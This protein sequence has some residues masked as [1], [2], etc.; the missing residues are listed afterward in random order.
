MNLP[1]FFGLDIGNHSLKVAEVKYSGNKAIIEH[2]GTAETQFSAIGIE[3]DEAAIATLADAIKNLKNSA[4]IKTNKVVAALPETI[5]FSRVI[6][7]PNTDEAKI[8][9]TVYWEAKQYIPIPIEDVNLDW[10]KIQEKKVGANTFLQL[11]IVA[12]PKKIVTHYQNL[13]QKAGLELIALETESVATS[14]IV[15]YRSQIDKPILVLDFG[16]VGTDMSVVKNGKLIFAQT[17]GTGSDALTKAIAND[18]GI[19]EQQAE[20]YKRAYGM[21]ETEG[22]GKIARS[23]KPVMEIVL[24]EIN[25]TVNYFK[26]HLQEGTPSTIYIVGD[27]SKLLG[28]TEFMG[29]KL[30]IA[31]EI[32]DP[33]RVIELDGGL[34]KELQ[35]SSLVNYTTSIGLGMKTE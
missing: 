18:Y 25:K 31:T 29:Q 23:I 19:S 8:E 11:L 6:E 27:G 5:I 12:A 9:E 35:Q 4:G 14:R 7:I 13:M 32:F 28:L 10:I 1:D 20:Q 21:L 2:V 3:S 33:S 26:A 30:G 16:A 22:E 15:S 34:K 17:L 24:N